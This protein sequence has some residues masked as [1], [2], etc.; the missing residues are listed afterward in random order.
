MVVKKVEADLKNTMLIKKNTMLIKINIML[1]KI[2]TMLIKK[3]GIFN[4]GCF[5]DACRY[6][7]H[8]ESFRP[9]VYY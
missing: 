6:I 5:N 1:I 4:D 9:Y 8:E 7:V 2:N 3:K